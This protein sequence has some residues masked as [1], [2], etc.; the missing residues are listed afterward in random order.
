M[1]A[2]VTVAVKPE[3]FKKIYTPMFDLGVNAKSES[4]LYD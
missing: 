3:Q 4:P 1:D 2:L